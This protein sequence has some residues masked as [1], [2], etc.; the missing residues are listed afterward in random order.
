MSALITHLRDRLEA[1]FRLDEAAQSPRRRRWLRARKLGYLSVRKIVGAQCL[2]RAATLSFTTTITLISLSILLI[3]VFDSFGTFQESL[4]ELRDFLGRY[5]AP[6]LEGE[7]DRWLTDI[8]ASLRASKAKAIQ[9]IAFVALV[10]AALALYRQAEKTFASIWNAPIRRG[11]IQKLGTFW[12]LLTAAPL[13]LSGSLYLKESLSSRFLPMESAEPVSAATVPEK[14]STGSW[15]EISREWLGP[16]SGF[17]EDSRTSRQTSSTPERARGESDGSRPAEARAP[18]GILIGLRN[19]VIHWMFPISLSFFAFTLLYLYLPGT[20]VSIHA[21]CCAALLAAICWQ[22][23]TWGFTSYIQSATL[24]GVYGV[25]GVIPSFLIW[26]YLSWFIALSGAAICYCLQSYGA[27]D[28]EM[29]YQIQH[30]RIAAPVYAVLF[31]EQIYLGFRGESPG[32][33]TKT[34]SEE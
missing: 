33:T 17:P 22:V 34:L 18:G 5:V 32:T 21:A 9:G 27:L 19:L 14:T 15:S 16:W 6:G 11:F 4:T 30:Q 23:S 28:L 1:L 29:R 7:V 20:R 31:L 10:I 3:F 24:S 26:L 12:L 13:I 25:L 2:E 8:E